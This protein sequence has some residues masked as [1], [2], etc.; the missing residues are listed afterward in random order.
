MRSA[1]VT[2]FRPRSFTNAERMIEEVRNRIFS[3]G[4]GYKDIATATGVSRSTIN[5]LAM[6]KTRWPRPTT[7]FPLL[8]AL[9]LHIQLVEDR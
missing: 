3:D 9:R 8:T 7:L 4:R 1:V 5:A 2:R 6:G